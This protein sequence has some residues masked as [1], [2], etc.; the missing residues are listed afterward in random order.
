MYEFSFFP[1]ELC[2]NVL[3]GGGE[4]PFGIPEKTPNMISTR[5]DGWSTLSCLHQTTKLAK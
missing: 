4:R 5:I 1:N 3:R 2:V